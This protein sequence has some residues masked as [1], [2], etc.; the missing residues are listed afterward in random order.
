MNVFFLIDTVVEQQETPEMDNAV[1]INAEVSVGPQPT[2]A[3]LLELKQQGF[4]TIINFRNEGEED[5]PLTPEIEGE[6]VKTLGMDYLHFPASIETMT[7]QAVDYFRKQYALVPHPA[8][9]HCRLGQRAAAMILMHVASEQGLSGDQALQKARDSG[10]EFDRDELKAIVRDYVNSR[11]NEQV[12][13][14][15]PK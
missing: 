6:K 3:Q 13:G 4:Q 1:R 14:S 10:Y 12:D 5:Q 7:P 8:F 9:A 15:H 11:S 2:E